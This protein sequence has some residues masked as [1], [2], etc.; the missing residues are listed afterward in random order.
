M[1]L[2]CSI[3]IPSSAEVLQLHMQLP[4]RCLTSLHNT[5]DRGSQMKA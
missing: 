2:A 4:E 1:L 5:R 3:L